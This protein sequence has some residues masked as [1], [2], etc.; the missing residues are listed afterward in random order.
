MV[1]Q[2]ETTETSNDKQWAFNVHQAIANV[3]L[4]GM[5]ISEELK[6]KMF[7]CTFEPTELIKYVQETLPQ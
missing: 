2:L 3:E 1:M 5:Q 6:K 4:E 7:D